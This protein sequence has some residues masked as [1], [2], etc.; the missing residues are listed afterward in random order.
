M[1]SPLGGS[2]AHRFIACPGSYNLIRGLPSYDDTSP[3]GEEW[4]EQGTAA[5]S[6][7]S[8]CIK[9]GVDAWEK[10]EDFPML[11]ADDGVAV[12]VA[13]DYARAQ[14]KEGADQY[15]EY[16]I[17]AKHLHP[18]LWGQLDWLQYDPNIGFLEIADYKHG[19]GVVVDI[20]DNAQIMY[21]AFC[22]L[23]DQRFARASYVKMTICQ[24]RAFHPGGPIRSTECDASDI[25]AWGNEVLIPAMVAAEKANDGLVTGP[26]CQFCPGKET[27]SCPAILADYTEIADA[28]EI[29]TVSNERLA[30]LFGKIQ[31]AMFVRK[32]LEKE[33]LR[34]RLLGMDIPNT[35][36]V[37]RKADRVYKDGAEIVLA[38]AF[39][40]DAYDRSLKSPAQMEKL[41]GGK[42]LVKHWAYTPD[43]GVTVAPLSDKR[44]AVELPK[45]SNAFQAYAASQE[46]EE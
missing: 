30:E 32:A 4:R 43:N 28:Q 45:A 14:K 46:E 6:L 15:S 33:T 35:K 41:T 38:E 2:A 34:R 27:L 42:V 18:L 19:A 12:Q 25:L 24:P 3:E 23:N 20:E 40:D 26:H 10:L 9:H 22:I 1:H 5:H 16:S 13:L 11:T 21:Y 37:R 8:E 39:G 17:D 31:T 44:K 36:L 7:L 29:E